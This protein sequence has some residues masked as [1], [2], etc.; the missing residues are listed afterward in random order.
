M[1]FRF[2]ILDF[3]LSLSLLS[4]ASPPS[5]GL[6]SLKLRARFFIVLYLSFLI[7]YS[8]SQKHTKNAFLLGVIP[9]FVGKLGFSSMGFYFLHSK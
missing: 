5:Y 9:F 6:A 8:M 1:S 3:V 4:Q 2:D 7:L